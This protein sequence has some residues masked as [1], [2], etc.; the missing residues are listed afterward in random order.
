MDTTQY[1]VGMD[2]FQ[3][4]LAIDAFS[5]RV[6]GAPSLYRNAMA[7]VDFLDAAFIGAK[8][9]RICSVGGSEFDNY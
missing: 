9:G 8:P 7:T 5:R 1:H 2:E 3:G 6:F 4:Y